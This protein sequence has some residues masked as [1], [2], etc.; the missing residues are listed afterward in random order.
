MIDELDRQ[1]VAALIRNGRAPFRHIAEVLQQQERTVARRANKLLASGAVRVQSFPSP[2]SLAR[3]DLYLLRVSAEPKALKKISEW[4]AARSDTHWISSLADSCQCVVEMY[5]AQEE[6]NSFLYEELAA[7]AGLK[8]FSLQPI[9]EYYRTVTGWRPQI[10]SNEQ[11]EQLSPDETP[12]LVTQWAA[13]SSPHTDEPSLNLIEALRANGRL[14]IE[15][16][17]STLGV[18]K[19]TASRRLD[20]LIADGTLFVRAILDPAS[21]GFPVESLV[22][23]QADPEELDR[24]GYDLAHRPTTRWAANVGGEIIVQSA[25]QNLAELYAILKEVGAQRR[26]REVM[27]SLVTGVHKRSTVAYVNGKLPALNAD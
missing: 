11:Y 23:V 20:M 25:H 10:L 24:V 22:T 16:I 9:F 6:V 17:A 21:I 7:F 27:M 14:T 5:L 2:S 18:S 3:V 26:V 1:I 12:G 4:L 15:E 19:T 8:D 13:T